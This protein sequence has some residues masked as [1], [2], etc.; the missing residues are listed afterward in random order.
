MPAVISAQCYHHMANGERKRIV[1]D[2]VTEEKTKDLNCNN[3][4][5]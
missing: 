1:F 5:T 4:Y 2:T 3:K